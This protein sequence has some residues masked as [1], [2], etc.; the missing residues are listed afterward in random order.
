V[1]PA[2]VSTATLN[3]ARNKSGSVSARKTRLY[4]WLLKDSRNFSPESSF[5]S[6]LCRLPKT[7][8]NRLITFLLSSLLVIAVVATTYSQ[9]VADP[10]FNAN[11]EH[12][13]FTKNFPRLL[14]DEAH[15]NFHTTTGRYKPFADLIFNDGYKVIVNRQPFTRASLESA[16]ILVISNALT[17][18][19]SPKKSPTLFAIGFAMVVRSCS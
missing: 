18:Q 16:R 8:T 5:C 2:P 1:C 15:N 7:M 11:V 3:V 13:A 6:R 4:C 17:A 12:P 14:F 9:Q 19:R 10:H